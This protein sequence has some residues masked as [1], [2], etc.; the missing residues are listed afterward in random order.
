MSYPNGEVVEHINLFCSLII[1]QAMTPL[2]KYN[3]QIVTRCQIFRQSCDIII[4]A[5]STPYS[6]ISILVLVVALSYNKGVQL[7]PITL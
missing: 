5:L 1:D 4:T 2:R 3:A 7:V 6:L